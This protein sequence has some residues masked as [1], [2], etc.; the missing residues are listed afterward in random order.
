[1]KIKNLL[2]LHEYFSL[3]LCLLAVSSGFA[4]IT[5]WLHGGFD[6]SS[7]NTLHKESK[8]FIAIMFNLAGIFSLVYSIQEFLKEVQFQR[9]SKYLV[10]FKE[11]NI[12]WLESVN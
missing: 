9:E 6:N 12:R 1:M 2:L 4:C 11:E 8:D 3:I 7:L 10:L 5:F